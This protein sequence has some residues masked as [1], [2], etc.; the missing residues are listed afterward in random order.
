MKAAPACPR[1]SACPLNAFLEILGDKW[2]LLIIRD[3]LFKGR[4]G[5]KDFLAGGE[6]V[7]T[8]ILANRLRQLES[9]GLITS[10]NDAADARKRVYHLTSKGLDLA[11]VLVEMILWGA[12]HY[13]TAA[14]PAVIRRMTR[15]RAGFLRELRELHEGATIAPEER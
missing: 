8:N 9:V 15:D 4:T 3:L 7:A 6:G 12:K 14:P 2:S 1:R 13:K 10:R 11:P 5:Y